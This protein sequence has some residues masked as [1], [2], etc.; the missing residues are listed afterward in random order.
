MQRMDMISLTIELKHQ[1]ILYHQIVKKK[2]YLSFIFGFKGS[3]LDTKTEKHE[4]RLAYTIQLCMITRVKRGD[5]ER[6]PLIR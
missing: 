2:N 6:D 1:H 3:G 5:R 4:T